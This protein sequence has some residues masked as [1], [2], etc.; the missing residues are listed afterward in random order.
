MKQKKV[1]EEKSEINEA[2]VKTKVRMTDN[3]DAQ[4]RREVENTELCVCMK[5]ICAHFR[6]AIA[7]GTKKAA[8]SCSN[9]QGIQF[10]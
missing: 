2:S 5:A 3:R 6:E 7:T 4:Q 8:L 9:Q 10:T 1:T